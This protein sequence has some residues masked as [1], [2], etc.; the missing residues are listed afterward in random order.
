MELHR[1]QYTTTYDYI[2]GKDSNGKPYTFSD[3]VGVISSSFAKNIAKSLDMCGCVPSCFQ[4]SFFKGLLIFY[5]RVYTLR[6]NV[7]IRFRGFKGVMSVDLML[8]SRKQWG[9][10]NAVRDGNSESKRWCYLDAVFRPSQEK[11][12]A[13]RATL[14]EIVKHSSP[15]PV[16]LNKPMINIL[17]QV[18]NWVCFSY[19]HFFQVSAMQSHSAH[20][21]ITNRIHWLLDRHLHELTRCLIDETR[22]R[23]KL[24]EFPKLILYDH[25]DDFNLTQE[26]FFRSLI[27]AACR[28]S[29][30]KLF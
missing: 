27:Q 2:G 20:M 15:V 7:Q 1:E 30:S 12:R 6:P 8:D 13:P 14:I 10:E 16:S 21:R 4:V 24:N 26:P 19:S 3:G 23:H 18:L 28:S 29:L 11:F 9:K 25:F 22:C 17:D 5:R